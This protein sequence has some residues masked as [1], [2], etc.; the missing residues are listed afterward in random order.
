[1]EVR[2]Q[3]GGRW[4]EAAVSK[5]RWESSGQTWHNL[6]MGLANVLGEGKRRVKDVA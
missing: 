1:M 6:V 4:G 2:E 3:P 5:W